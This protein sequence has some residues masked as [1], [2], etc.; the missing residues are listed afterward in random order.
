MHARGCAAGGCGARP[1]GDRAGHADAGGDRADAAQLRRA[2]GRARALGLRRRASPDLRR[3]DRRRGDRPR[4]SRCSSPCSCRAAPTRSR[5]SIRTATRSIAS[6]GRARGSTGGTPFAEDARLMWHPALAPI[7]QLHAEG[8]VSVLPAVGYDHPD[9]SHF[10]SRHF[11]EVG[12]T[13][14]SLLT[15]LD[16]SLPRRDRDAR[17]PVAGPLD[18]RVA[19][20]DARD[21]EGAGRRDR[22]ARPVRLLGAGCVGRSRVADARCDRH[23]RP[24]SARAIPPCA[25]SPASPRRS[26]RCAGSSSRSAPRAR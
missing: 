22:R 3:G 1:A 24:R 11:W 23:A 17:Q 12:A 20:A 19:A 21:R 13:E 16:G 2:L 14:P 18:D 26:T 8:K 5:C 10:T 9:Q 6:C 15:G 4:P 25:R 7:A